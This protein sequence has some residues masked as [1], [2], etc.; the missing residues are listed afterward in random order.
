MNFYYDPIL[1]LTYQCVDPMVWF[2][3]NMIPEQMDLARLI[4]LTRQQ[5]IMVVNSAV[6]EYKVT[7]IRHKITSN[8]LK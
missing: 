3:I 6:E 4:A 2:D 8:F 1:G 7:D 5:G